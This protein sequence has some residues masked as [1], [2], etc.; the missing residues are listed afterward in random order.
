MAWGDGAAF[1]KIVFSEE[2]L[3]R[4]VRVFSSD[5]QVKLTMSS[6]WLSFESSKQVQ[7]WGGPPGDL[8]F[9]LDQDSC[10][11][12]LGPKVISD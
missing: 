4:C 2:S 11:L 1:C 6:N 7:T 3:S 9:A 10:I 8:L 12:S 5:E